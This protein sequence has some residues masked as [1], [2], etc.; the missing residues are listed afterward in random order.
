MNIIEQEVG[1]GVIDEYLQ[2]IGH[3]YLS[4][5]CGSG[6]V[7]GV[8]S[9]KLHAYVKP[10]SAEVST[11]RNKK[12][13][14]A[15]K[16][17]AGSS[18]Q[19]KRKRGSVTFR[20]TCLKEGSQYAGL[21]QTAPVLTKAE[22]AV[23]AAAEAYAKRLAVYDWNSAGHTTIIDDQSD[24]YKI[25]GNSLLSKEMRRSSWKRRKRRSRKLSG[26]NEAKWSGS[27]T[28]MV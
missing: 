17:A 28:W 19:E 22:A 1:K 25:E 27:L 9:S 16:E 15:S 18:S 8:S 24:H 13:P 21:D 12:P 6:S 3:S 14:R 23:E 4:S 5:S 10:P 2:Q 20:C 11:S 26:P 7:F